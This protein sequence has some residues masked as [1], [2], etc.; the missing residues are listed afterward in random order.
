MLNHNEFLHKNR[1]IYI[2]NYPWIGEIYNMFDAV[3]YGVGLEEKNKTHGTTENLKTDNINIH[4][5]SDAK[6]RIEKILD[7]YYYQ[8][9]NN[10]YYHNM[11]KCGDLHIYTDGR[12]M[13]FV[14]A[15]N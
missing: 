13:K 10:N 7:I 11:K 2:K 8:F 6:E 15:K 12:N 1:N 9:I 5:V 3:V 4:N 14:P